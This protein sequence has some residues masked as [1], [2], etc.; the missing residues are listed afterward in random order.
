MAVQEI[1][2]LKL[3]IERAEHNAPNDVI[4][5]KIVNANISQVGK[6]FLDDT[7]QVLHIGLEK[8]HKHNAFITAELM[9]VGDFPFIGLQSNLEWRGDAKL[10]QVVRTTTSKKHGN[11]LAPQKIIKD[12]FYRL[13]L[14]CP[15]TV[16]ECYF[17]IP[18]VI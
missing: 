16:N 1:I 8:K 10:S 6:S 13:L 5:S 7:R 15:E 3:A 12:K 2:A 9:T 18:S 17:S 14:R 4:V 11:Q